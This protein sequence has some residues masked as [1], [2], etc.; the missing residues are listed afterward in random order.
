M[1]KEELFIRNKTDE[2]V[3]SFN[4]TNLKPVSI[5]FN[6]IKI[7]GTDQSLVLIQDLGLYIRTQNICF[8]LFARFIRL[9]MFKHKPTGCML[10]SHPV[11]S[12][13]SLILS[14]PKRESIWS[15]N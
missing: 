5:L 7:H 14:K 15:V 2:L 4:V 9:D 10:I 6:E 13:E 1:K 3:T 12:P 11:F 8:I